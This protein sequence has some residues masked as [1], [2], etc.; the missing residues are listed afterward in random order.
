MDSLV[1]P[2]LFRILCSYL[3]QGISIW[4]FPIKG[5]GFLESLREMEKN[6]FASFFRKK[7]ARKLLL[8]NN[9]EISD[10]LKTL[11]GDESLY[12]QYLFDQQFAHQGWSG[13]VSIVES[14]PQTL[15]DTRKI[16]MHDLIVFEL[17]LE[18]DAMDYHFGREWTPLANHIEK[19]PEDLFAE[20]KETEVR[21]VI[22]IWQEAF[23]WSY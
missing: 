6:S 2:I 3:D 11:V 12:K 20:V 13:M 5:L 23:E 16:S 18:I 4:T 7:K 17:L 14:N 9:C 15:L 19:K 1:H 10:L 22:S 21:E 8:D